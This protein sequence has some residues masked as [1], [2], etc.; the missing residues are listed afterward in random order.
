[1]DIADLARFLFIVVTPIVVVA[2]ALVSLF[3][4]GALF[5]GLEHPDELRAKVQ[6][7]FRRPPAQPKTPGKDHYYR[8]YWA[9]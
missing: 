9:R 5:W 8:P 4:V 3:A 2:G 1:M 7:A 6:A